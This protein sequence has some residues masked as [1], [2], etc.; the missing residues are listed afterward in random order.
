MYKPFFLAATLLLAGAA[1]AQTALPP[2]GK[3]KTKHQRGQ[4]E[5]E[6]AATTAPAAAATDYSLPYAASITPEGLK[7]DLDVL[8]SDAY[9]GRET[10]QKGQKMAADYLAGAGVRQPLL[11]ALWPGA[12]R[13]GRVGQDWGPDV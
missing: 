5:T 9:E 2:T 8:A 1:T 11:S 4:A 3:V 13:P 12:H 10:G 7:T 6:A